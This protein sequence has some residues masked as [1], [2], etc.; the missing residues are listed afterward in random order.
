MKKYAKKSTDTNLRTNKLKILNSSIRPKSTIFQFGVSVIPNPNLCYIRKT[1]KIDFSNISN[2]TPLTSISDSL[3]TVNFSQTLNKGQ[4]PN[5]WIDWSSPPQS[6]SSKPDI[7]FCNTEKLTINLTQPSQIF[8][9]ELEPNSFSVSTYTINFYNGTTLLDTITHQFVGAY[10]AILVA[11][12]S[13]CP[14]DCVEIMGTRSYG[15]SIAQIRYS[16][17]NTFCVEP[18]N[19]NMIPFT[20]T[21]TSPFD[22]H[23]YEQPK[24]VGYNIDTKCTVDTCLVPI[25]IPLPNNHSIQC[26]TPVDKLTFKGTAELLLSANV[27]NDLDQPNGLLLLVLYGTANISIDQVFYT[28]KEEGHSQELII[29]TIRIGRNSLREIVI[30]GTVKF[31]LS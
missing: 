11:L 5:T 7:L 31:K 13:E 29:D 23:D 6:E 19:E 15:F 3:Q 30:S 21:I 8:G 16:I 1:N 2:H 4:V 10:N 14:I 28:C 24:L 27:T 17:E 20:T 9:F 18:P 26:C 22:I 25:D 12:I